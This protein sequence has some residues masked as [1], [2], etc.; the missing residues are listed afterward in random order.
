MHHT[1]P[2]PRRRARLSYTL[3]LAT[4]LLA[5]CGEK[6]TPPERTAVPPT[7][8]PQPASAGVPWRSRSQLSGGFEPETALALPGKI[9]GLTLAVHPTDGWPAVA[10]IR[11]PFPGVGGRE[12]YVRSF[13]PRAGRFGA[14]QQLAL[15]ASALGSDG[16]ADAALAVRGDGALLAV[17]GPG[18]NPQRYGQIWSAISTDY[19]ASWGAPTELRAGCKHIA[20]L[21]LDAAWDGALLLICEEGRGTSPVLLTLR[22]GAPSDAQ[23]LPIAVPYYAGGA[24]LVCGEGDARSVAA[25][26]PLTIAGEA[27]LISAIRRIG[28]EG[29]HGE[30]A[31]RMRRT[32]LP[33]AP[34][35]YDATSA[36]CH[37]PPGE[38]APQIDALVASGADALLVAVS[39]SADALGAPQ[40]IAHGSAGQRITSPSIVYRA[41]SDTLLASWICC[42]A[43]VFVA[44]AAGFNGAAKTGGGR[45]RA[46]GPLLAG[47]T[48]A[49]LG[50]LRSAPGRDSGTLAWVERHELAIVR[51]YTIDDDAALA[52]GGALR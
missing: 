37:T 13:D 19:G 44:D 30:T 46:L 11:W 4:A 45:W 18:D 33:A 1:Q 3:L 15:G 28:R 41:A 14:P 27:A 40:V 16:F 49:S 50:A 47:E 25:L 10:A 2:Q 6:G 9:L 7:V 20:A 5:A 43:D 12:L 22:G 8:T 24:A 21:A 29:A 35:G 34:G 23:T 26:L 51:R 36:V 52:T 31:W 42:A 48:S 39:G 32:P 17:W 38:A